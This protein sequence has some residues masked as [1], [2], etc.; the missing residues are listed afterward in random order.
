M[1][2]GSGLGLT[3][4]KLLVELMGGL[5]WSKKKKGE[6]QGERGESADDHPGRNGS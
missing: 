5:I 1:F 3:I 2:G 6:K 4:S